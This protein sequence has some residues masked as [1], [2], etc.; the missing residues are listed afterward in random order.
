MFRSS[1]PLTKIPLSLHPFLLGPT[2]FLPRRLMISLQMRR[3]I[4]FSFVGSSQ[5]SSVG[6][7]RF[8][9]VAVCSWNNWLRVCSHSSGWL[10]NSSTRRNHLEIG[11]FYSTVECVG[12]VVG[13]CCLYHRSALY[14]GRRNQSA[15]FRSNGG[16][17]STAP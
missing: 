5:V 6:Y 9:S 3:S 13:T 2:F 14:Q 1:R 15:C 12:T 16:V 11:H 8:A 4:L 17:A 7:Q 10:F